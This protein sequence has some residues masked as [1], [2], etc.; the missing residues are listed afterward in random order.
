MREYIPEV[1][2]R[3]IDWKVMLVD[4]KTKKPF[5]WVHVEKSEF[6]TKDEAI[7]YLV[8]RYETEFRKKRK[9]TSKSK[10]KCRCK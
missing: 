10:R 6:P 7:D 5:T 1:E 4:K 8:G 2:E 9:A 3:E